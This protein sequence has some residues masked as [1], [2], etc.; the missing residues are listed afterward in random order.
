MNPMTILVGILVLCLA[1]TAG[2]FIYPLL[3]LIVIGGFKGPR[4]FLR[5]ISLPFSSLLKRDPHLSKNKAT[6][7]HGTAYS[8]AKYPNL[9]HVSQRESRFE[10]HLHNN[11]VEPSNTKE[12]SIPTVY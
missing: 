2:K 8:E 12:S 11:I 10:Y 6:R 3:K 7:S 5:I 9:N 1:L 4:I